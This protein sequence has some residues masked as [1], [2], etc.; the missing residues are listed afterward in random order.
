AADQRDAVGEQG[1]R[2]RVA[3]MAGQRAAVEG[4]ADRAVAV[5][6][7]AGGGAARAH[8]GFFRLRVAG[9]AAFLA[10]LVRLG[11]AVRG[12]VFAAFGAAAAGAW[13]AR[14]VEWIS[15]VV[16]SRTTTR[17]ARQPP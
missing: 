8:A 11:L 12:A 7:P 10:A 3:G 14:A 13:R 15:W 16:V 2:Q 4:E 6:A 5:D 1:R 17:C 9:F